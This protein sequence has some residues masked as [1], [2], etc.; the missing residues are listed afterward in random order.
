M[1]ITI[2]N[3]KLSYPHLFKPTSFDG[4]AEQAKYTT[5]IIIPKDSEAASQLR[6]EYDKVSSNAVKDK[7]LKRNQLTPFIRAVGTT[8]GILVDCDDDLDRYPPEIYGGCYI[9]RAKSKRKPNVV[10]R[11][12]SPISEEDEAIYG[13]VM[14]NVNINLYAY[15]KIGAGIAVGLNGVQ[16]IADGDPIGEGRPSVASMF[17]AADD[18]YA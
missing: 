1:A 18:I 14:A 12:L 7:K 11:M 17:E 9:L 6:T 8:A 5:D 16:K 15:N 10:D 3:V 13:G 4:N 2:K